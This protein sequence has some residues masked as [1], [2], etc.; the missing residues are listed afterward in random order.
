PHGLDSARNHHQHARHGDPGA[1]AAI[2]GFEY[3]AVQVWERGQRRD[4]SRSFS[5]RRSID[6]EFVADT[7]QSG[8]LSHAGAAEEPQPV[9]FAGDREP[10]DARHD[11]SIDQHAHQSP[12]FRSRVGGGIDNIAFL[13]GKP[14]GGPNASAIPV[15]SIFWIERVRDHSGNE[16]DQL[17]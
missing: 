1:R 6:P 10:D 13:V 15:T 8:R 2:R 4:G 7:A 17:Q 16:F 9:S 3:Y 12:D 14:P 11:G 5:R